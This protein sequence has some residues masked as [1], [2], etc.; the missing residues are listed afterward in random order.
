MTPACSWLLG[1]GNTRLH[2]RTMSVATMIIPDL[3]GLARNFWAG[4]GWHNT[5]P[6]H[7]EHVVPLKLPLVIVKQTQTN[8]AAASNWL[9]QRGIV[10]P[11]P[12]DQP[13]LCGC[14]V[15]HRGHGFIFV[16][17]TDGAEEQRLT[18]AHE[19]AHFLADYLLP[20]QQ[21]FQALGAHMAE[22]LDGLR[23]PTPAE[24]AAAILSH[25]RL[26][27]HI[28]L[29]PRLGIDVE[30]DRTVVHAEDRADR[31]ALELVAPQ[32]CVRNVL[33]A[34]LNHQGVTPDDVRAALATHFGLPAYAFNKTIQRMVRRPLRSFAEDIRAGLRKQH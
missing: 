26:G 15:A 16:S 2:I 22:V 25:V 31:L 13:A 20:R 9:Q 33:N 10:I 24:R 18:V 11:V 21:V 7:I 30:D 32:A 14:L 17:A 4:T 1:R 12:D 6:R 27:A 3:E 34:L 19:V 23:R 29:L 8:V 5:F 28:H